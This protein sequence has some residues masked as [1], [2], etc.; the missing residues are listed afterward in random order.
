MAESTPDFDALEMTDL[1]V[2]TLESKE[3]YDELIAQGFPQP[4]AA[5]II[6]H[7]LYDVMTSRFEGSDDDDEWDDDPIDGPVTS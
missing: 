1:A 2:W 4:V 3:M 6:A 7:I 5:Q